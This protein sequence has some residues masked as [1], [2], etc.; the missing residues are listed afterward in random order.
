MPLKSEL[1]RF[2]SRRC[3]EMG[4]AADRLAH[5]AGVDPQTVDD[6]LAR[7]NADLDVSDA[8][9][10]ANAVGLALGVVGQ[11]PRGVRGTP[12]VEVAA[13]AASTS[14]RDLL[15]PGTLLQ[16]LTSGVVPDHFR[17]QLRLLLEE[18][19]VGLLARVADEIQAELAVPAGSTW[20]TMRAMALSLGCYRDIWS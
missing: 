16:T 4:L 11:P 8:E 13:R 3:E 10:I 18:A 6:L 14:Y 1:A 19:P 15:P 7:R 2:V 20:K 5:I 17:P 9:Q 12:A